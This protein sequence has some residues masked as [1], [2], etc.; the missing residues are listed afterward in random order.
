MGIIQVRRTG[1]WD[2]VSVAAVKKGRAREFYEEEFDDEEDVGGSGGGGG[3]KKMRREGY[4]GYGY[5][6]GSGG[7]SGMAGAV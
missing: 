1:W 5:G 2:P 3:G 7:K 4:D 6:S